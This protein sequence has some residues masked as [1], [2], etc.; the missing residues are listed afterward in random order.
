VYACSSNDSGSGPA[1]A[2]AQDATGDVIE[3]G[4]LPDVGGGTFDSYSN[5]CTLPNDGSDPV[6]LCL[7]QQVLQFETQYAYA[8][9]KGV[10]PGWSS[11]SPYA[12]STG[13][14]WR[15]DVGLAGAIGSYHCSSGVYGNDAMTP[16]FDALLPDLG[17]TITGELQQSPP[18]DYDGED[19]FRLRWAQAAFYY[20]DDNADGDTL[21][22]AA[23]AYA[24]NIVAKYT[25]VVA[26][27]GGA[28]DGGVDAG[29]G[30]PGGIVIGKGNGDGSVTYEP[31][32]A[33]MAAAA[34]LDMA[35][36]HQNDPDAGS[37]PQA[38][39]EAGVAA[40]QYL[41]ARAMDPQT[42]L[43][44]QSLTT[45]LAAGHD[46]LA[47]GT[48]APDALLGDVQATIVLALARI[49][50]SVDALPPPGSGD[51]GADA[52][53]ASAPLQPPYLV[54]AA[55]LGDAMTK[56]MLW[57]GPTA[58]A[59]DGGLGSPGAF[60]EG[61][62]PSAGGALLTN[63]TVLTSAYFLGGMHRV[64]LGQGYDNVYQLGSTRSALTQLLPGHSSFLSAVTDMN[65]NPL[66]QAYLRA[67]SKGWSYA[68]SFDADGGAGGQEPGATSYQS[69][70]GHAMI[71]GLAQLWHGN[72]HGA[73][74]PPP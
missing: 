45:S 71:E 38:W 25:H 52:S 57:D 9:G 28:G 59:A 14:D 26:G 19:Y 70:A 31:A 60:L 24:A 65:G 44:Y 56:A 37:G 7:Q 55:A 58:A 63:K 17:M 46:D 20:V 8:K 11:Q 64:A 12:P 61:L 54:M 21:K 68:V 22:A 40:V 49:Q 6:S 48:P 43:F 5:N 35:L 16:A 69:A 51:G 10:A 67:T 29:G 47:G 13:H 36:V 62:L 41:A 27:G 3:A 32:K 30:S 23:D 2:S 72:P 34:L 18:D 53:D 1:D 33:M 73:S 39:Q 42:G 15:D 50:A 74:C 66:Q 4:G